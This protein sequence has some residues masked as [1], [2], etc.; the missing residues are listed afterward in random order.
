MKTSTKRLSALVSSLV[1]LSILACVAPEENNTDANNS[2]DCLVSSSTICDPNNPALILRIDACGNVLGAKQTCSA[3]KV[4]TTEDPGNP[5]REINPI[6]AADASQPQCEGT[7]TVCNPDNALEI[8]TVDGCGETVEVKQTCDA[9][10]VC[11]DRDPGNPAREITPKCV[12]DTQGECAGTSEICDPDDSSQILTVDGCG[13]TVEVKESCGE[14]DI[15]TDRDPGNPDR[16]I[17]PICVAA[18]GSKMAASTCDPADLTATYYTDECGNITTVAEQCEATEECAIDDDGGAYCACQPTG[19]NRCWYDNYSSLYRDS[20]IAVEYSCATPN[21]DP[22]LAENLVEACEW[23]SVCTIDDLLNEGAATCAR[24]ITAD[25]K[26]APYYNHG[27]SFIDYVRSPTSLEMDCRCRY[28]GDSQD[29]TSPTMDQYADPNGGDRPGGAIINCRPTAEA[30]RV[31]WP[32]KYGDGP[33]FHAWYQQNA[34]GE[35]WIGGDIHP[36]KRELYGV[37]RWTGPTHCRSSTIVAWDLDTKDRRIVSGLYPDPALGL[38]PHGSG[39]LS[40]KPTGAPC[41]TAEQPLTGVAAMVFGPDKMLYTFGGGTGEA[42]TRDREIVKTDPTTGARTLVWQSQ[43]DETGDISATFGQCLRET[44]TPTTGLYESVAWVGQAFAVGPDGTFYLSFRGSQEGDGIASISAD[45]KTCTILSRWGGTGSHSSI[46]QGF[47]LQFPVYGMLF[48]DNKVYGVSNDDLYSFDVTTGQ[49][50]KIST[51]Q[52]TYGGMGYSNMFWDDTRSVFWAV[53]TVAPY[54]GSIVDPATGRRESIYG[55]SG[56][57]EF[58]DE[59]IL[60]SD[61][62]RKYQF[63]RSVDGTMLSNANSIN[64]GPVRLDPDDNNIVWAVLKGGSL[65]KLELSTFNNYIHSF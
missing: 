45:G 17:N 13:E 4:C 44:A 63:E 50:I 34:S 14:G 16:E 25:Q 5:G 49:R 61:Y 41:T 3:G 60:Q 42:W 30:G 24:S 52:G 56:Y 11:S 15:C 33:S 47:T 64:Y 18:C 43:N 21:A 51:H 35:T 19:A 38:T 32:V 48:K 2:Q 53:G 58:G 39:H 9:G 29:N 6:C 27:C 8:L 36:D 37:V 55:D 10:K 59:A 26:D 54:V 7:S 46:G 40:R 62:A 23:G 57:K 20:H 31:S 65:M 1:G 22:T 28:V 12:A